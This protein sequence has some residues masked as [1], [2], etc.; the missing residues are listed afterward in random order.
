MKA[1]LLVLT[2]LALMPL[3]IMLLAWEASSVFVSIRSATGLSEEPTSPIQLL[4]D[5]ERGGTDLTWM[6]PTTQCVCG[7]ELWH[8]VC[9][10]DP[11]E[12]EVAGRFLEMAC[13]SCGSYCK[14][15]TPVD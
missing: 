1:I 13:V 3:S 6:G 4:L 7:S 15:P 14:S 11:H 9:W 2:R 8:I 10:F 12:R 5:M